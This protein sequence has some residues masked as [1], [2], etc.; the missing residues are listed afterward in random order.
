M[1]IFV[2]LEIARVPRKSSRENVVIKMPINIPAENHEVS[3]LWEI[4]LTYTDLFG[5]KRTIEIPRCVSPVSRSCRIRLKNVEY[6]LSLTHSLQCNLKKYS[7]AVQF[8]LNFDIF[9]W[10]QVAGLLLSHQAKVNIK[11]YKGNTP[12]HLCCFTGHLDPASVLIGVRWNSVLSHDNFLYFSLIVYDCSVGKVSRALSVLLEWPAFF[13]YIELCVFYPLTFASLFVAWVER[14]TLYYL[15]QAHIPPWYF[16]S[17]TTAT[18]QT[19][20]NMKTVRNLGKRATGGERSI[21]K[22]R[23]CWRFS[24]LTK[25]IFP[26]MVHEF[27]DRT[28]NAA[29]FISW[30]SMEPTLMWRMTV[31][32]LHY[33]KQPGKESLV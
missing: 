23:L 33:T 17:P 15:V 32:T 25:K 29:M 2:Q 26:L 22:V 3:Q 28:L 20:E 11:D 21:S 31:E 10:F 13:L 14:G 8:F 4:Q 19:R 7:G 30:Y 16:V 6:L 27:I 24:W 1:V 18:R 12:L 9:Y 5:V